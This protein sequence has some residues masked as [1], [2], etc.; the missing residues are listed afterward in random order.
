MVWEGL[1]TSACAQRE[2]R[3]LRRR[4]RRQFCAGCGATFVPA[5]RDARYCGNACRQRA[6]RVK[7]AARLAARRASIDLAA[8]LIG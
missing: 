2:R 4:E 8:S 1:T 7:K 3:A 6:Y 5:R